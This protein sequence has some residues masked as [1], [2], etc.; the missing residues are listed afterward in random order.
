[1]SAEKYNFDQ[2]AREM[3]R[4]RAAGTPDAPV[5]AARIARELIVNGIKGTRGAAADQSPHESVRLICKGTISALI[6]LEQKVP[7]GAVEI[8]RQLGDAAQ[9]LGL[10]P[11]EMMTWAMEGVADNAPALS[12]QQIGAVHSAIDAAF[13]GAGQVFSELCAKS[14]G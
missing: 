6:L 9:E 12:A 14:R 11:Q 5:Q 2:L 7:E 4:S 1:M 13:M 10:D 3:V 8:M